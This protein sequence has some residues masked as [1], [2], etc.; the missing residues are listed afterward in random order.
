LKAKPRTTMRTAHKVAMWSFVG[1]LA[2]I[3]FFGDS[4][5][6]ADHPI[7]FFLFFVGPP[8]IFLIALL[9]G[10]TPLID[11]ETR[12]KHRSALEAYEQ[13]KVCMR[14]GELYISK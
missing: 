7:L 13:T 11:E 12:E 4:L 8:V 1:F 2:A 5:S 9:I 6:S 10:N 14:C 3:F